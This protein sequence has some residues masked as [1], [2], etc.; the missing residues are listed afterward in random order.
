MVLSHHFMSRVGRYRNRTPL[1]SQSTREADCRRSGSTALTTTIGSSR[2]SA[3]SGDEPLEPSRYGVATIPSANVVPWSSPTVCASPRTAAHSLGDDKRE[4]GGHNNRD[5]FVAFTHI[6]THQTPYVRIT[7]LTLK[8]IYAN[9]RS[10]IEER[11]IL[12][13]LR[14]ELRDERS[15]KSR[16]SSCVLAAM[17]LRSGLWPLCSSDR[18]TNA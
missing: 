15:L 1:R 14:T 12:V 13:L 3:K 11:S 7:G 6:E 10:E 16:P 18:C 8:L 2:K 5:S 4:L 17:G 9:M